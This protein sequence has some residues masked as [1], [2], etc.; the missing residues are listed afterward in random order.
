MVTL[1]DKVLEIDTLAVHKRNKFLL[2]LT[3]YVFKKW[4]NNRSNTHIDMPGELSN[5]IHS[6]DRAIMFVSSHKSLWE[7][8]GIPYAIN[9]YG[10]DI[11]YIV[12]GS[13]LLKGVSFL[14]KRI[15]IINSERGKKKSF[16][17]PLQLKAKMN[18]ALLRGNQ[19]LIFPENGRTRTGLVD[20]FSGTATSS[21]VEV[22]K[23]IDTYI[24]PVNVDYSDMNFKAEASLLKAKKAY[25]FRLHHALYWIKHMEDIFISFGNPIKISPA[26]NKDELNDYVRNQCMNLVKILPINIVSEAATRALTNN[27]QLS[28]EVICEYIRQELIELVPHKERFRI[29]DPNSKPMVIIKLSGTPLLRELDKVYNLYAGYIHHYFPNKSRLS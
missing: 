15:G 29:F 12:A 16:R 14:T 6:N 25:T 11:P 10:G 2:G 23:Y 19:L 3:K 18:Y 26:D 28:N 5:L 13:N 8:I 22:S 24:V 27:N 1:E 21:A 9:R 17:S 7:T 20:K 4:I